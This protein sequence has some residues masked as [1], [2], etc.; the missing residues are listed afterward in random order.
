MFTD[1]D[2]LIVAETE[3]E[4]DILGHVYRDTLP[5]SGNRKQV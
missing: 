4:R 1:I 5:D 2:F 3:Q